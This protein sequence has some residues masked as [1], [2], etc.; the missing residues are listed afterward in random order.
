MTAILLRVNNEDFKADLENQ[1]S[2]LVADVSFSDESPDMIIVD[3]DKQSLQELRSMFPYVPVIYLAQDINPQEDALN[4]AVKKPLRLMCLLDIIRSANNRLDNSEEGVLYFNGFCLYPNKRIIQSSDADKVVKLTEKEVDI[5]KYLY[6][7]S[8][9]FVD[10]SDLQKN[11][12]QYSN[13]V[14]THTIETHI[15][16]LRQKVETDENHRLIET[17]GG[18]Y[19]LKINENA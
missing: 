6:R 4:I 13:D 11:V 8:D 5:I 10:K 3:E 15:Y 17:N 1:I 12:W 7:H 16:R 9:E 14:T 2:R 19:K 18:K